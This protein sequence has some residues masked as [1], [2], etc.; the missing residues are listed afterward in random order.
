MTISTDWSRAA[1]AAACV[2]LAAA[3]ACAS[4]PVRRVSAIAE[5]DRQAKQA[6][7]TESQIDPGRIPARS[8]G[9][10]PFAV[11]E[12]DTLLRPLGYA[13]AEFMVSDLSHSSELQMVERLRTD[14]IFRELD[15]VDQGIVD[16]RTAPR[17]GRLVGARRLLVGEVRAAPG[18][19]VEFSARVVDVVAGT[20]EQ[21]VSATAPLG[22]I[23][24]AEK[25]LALR[26][27]EELGIT[28]TPA[29]RVA[30][31]Q[32]QTTNLAATVAYGRG[33]ESEAHGDETGA[34]ASFQEAARLDASFVAARTQLAS[35]APGVSAQHGAGIKRVLDLSAQAINGP[36]TTKL[37]EAADV[38]LS[39]SQLLTLLITVRV[40]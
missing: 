31:E 3:T 14:A 1:R 36:V 2:V 17:V 8:F 13:M 7:A 4:V 6:L 20:V 34:M 15:L 37:P 5:A 11:A 18:D 39:S 40:F 9:V 19:A 10:L 23:I 30:V 29:Q 32:R 21:L 26:V 16:P 24:D 33:L 25:V 38:P 12:R 22:R 27:F 28:L 35:A